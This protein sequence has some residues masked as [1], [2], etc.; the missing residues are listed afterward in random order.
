M[1]TPPATLS[2]IG[3]NSPA[4]L[5]A[6]PDGSMEHEEPELKERIT[7]S[8]ILH[9]SET[10]PAGK[11]SNHPLVTA[12]HARSV[13]WPD[14][15]FKFL[16][17]EATPEPDFLKPVASETVNQIIAGMLPSPIA[18]TKKSIRDLGNL[19][20]SF[21]VK[22][23]AGIMECEEEIEQGIEKGGKQEMQHSLSESLATCLEKDPAKGGSSKPRKSHVGLKDEVRVFSCTIIVDGGESCADLQAGHIAVDALNES[24]RKAEVSPCRLIHSIPS[25]NCTDLWANS[26]FG[27]LEVEGTPKYVDSDD[28]SNFSD[29]IITDRNCDHEKEKAR[30]ANSTESPFAK[31]VN[32][33]ISDLGMTFARVTSELVQRFNC[34]D[35]S[36]SDP[37]EI[38]MGMPWLSRCH[39]GID[40]TIS[41]NDDYY[42]VSD[43]ISSQDKLRRNYGYSTQDARDSRTLS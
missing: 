25:D 22:M 11:P 37:D 31:D 36:L 21:K 9:L 4:V 29:F 40:R 43:Y 5:F 18:S 26:Q 41:K 19:L 34:S 13:V 24:G 12:V 3:C 35:P 6:T 16:T 17:R 10:S 38:T 7:D 23:A 8:P 39:G 15:P 20:K 1:S 27:L 32:H 33:M 42:W 28:V 30:V 2:T 14:I